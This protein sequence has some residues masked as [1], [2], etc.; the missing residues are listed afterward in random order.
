[1]MFLKRGPRQKVKMTFGEQNR[2]IS[3]LLADRVSFRKMSEMERVEFGLPAANFKI[4]R[5][6]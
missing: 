6:G 5:F 4:D 1:M 3:L 2:F